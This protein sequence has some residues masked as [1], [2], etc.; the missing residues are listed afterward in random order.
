MGDGNDHSFPSC[1]Y[2]NERR[3]SDTGGTNN[4]K[5]SLSL[6]FKRKGDYI[7]RETM[8]QVITNQASVA[9]QYNGQSASAISN[10]ATATLT[11]PLSVEKVSVESVYR[12]GEEVTYSISFENSG[13]TALT[14]VKI[15]DNL[16][17]YTLAG[18]TTSVT[19]LRYVAP[20][21]LL[22]DG[23]YSGNITPTVNSDSVVFTVPALAVSSR[24]Q[25]I[26]K[27]V[28]NNYAPLGTGSQITNTVSLTATGVNTPITD[29]NT[30]TV[31]DYAEI[32]VTKNMSP[33]NVVDG[34][35]LTYTFVINN[36]GNATAEEIV[37]HDTFDPAP[38][39]IT[40]QLNGVTKPASSYS[41]TNGVLTYPVSTSSES[42]S[43]PPATIV[44]D[45][46]S[47]EVSITPSSLT[48]TVTGVL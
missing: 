17:T 22:I 35:A 47:G 31:A 14:E 42:L 41:Y 12:Y 37:L 46:I 20:A 4:G 21:I 9:Y 15:T 38:D 8:A 2:W 6:K 45:P 1:I 24:A 11:E 5:L 18:T 16:G 23:A 26:Y 27:A 39:T 3:R 28:V 30:I 48:I 36:Y 34:D 19:P 7:Q 10:I 33:A 40:L 29:D 32:A 43:L 44:Q 25:I 13:N